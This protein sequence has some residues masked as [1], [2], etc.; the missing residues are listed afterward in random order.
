MGKSSLST[1]E[2]DAARDISYAHA[3][4]SRT[5]RALIR[6]LEN[7]TGR[8][9]LIRRADGYQKEVDA[10]TDFWNVMVERYGLSLD[11]Q[12]EELA[13]IPKDGPLV[14]VANHPFGI[15]DGLMI[16]HILA[17]V[18][19]KD[20]RIL[21]HRVFRKAEDIN[22]IILP[23]SFDETREATEQNLK[24]RRDALQFLK[25]G[26]AIGVFPGGTVSTSQ[27]LLSRP[28]DPAWRTFTAKM[29]VKSGATVIPVYF[30]GQNSRLF[31]MASH[32]HPNLRVAL[33]INE[34]RRR[35]DA[36]VRATLGA[37]IERQELE[38]LARDGKAM[39]DF[40]RARTYALSE[41]GRGVN[42]Y[43]FEFEEKRKKDRGDGGRHSRQR[44]WRS[45][46]VQSG[47]RAAS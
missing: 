36:T 32:L 30:Q 31:Q 37:P 45:D 44:T 8:I 43:G 18:R 12:G 17:Q 16:G 42:A 46:R 39:M 26:G 10:G 15:L 11:I 13:A 27:T 25:G 2:K 41:D 22:R 6:T 5:G 4:R 7:A 38:A 28:L 29:I 1:I 9:Q 14:L 21:A 24:T 34:F 40:L 19:G 33:L 3:A 47:D 23:I 35:T 20:F